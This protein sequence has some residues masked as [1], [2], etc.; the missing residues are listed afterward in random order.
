[1]LYFHFSSLTT[2]RDEGSR[3]SRIR[4]SV[5][6]TKKIQFKFPNDYHAIGILQLPYGNIVEP[7]EMW[8]SGKNKMSR[9]DYYGGKIGHYLLLEIALASFLG[10]AFCFASLQPEIPSLV[11][12]DLVLR[13]AKIC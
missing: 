8:Y 6:K 4:R 7:F 5:A 1:M 12:S 9:M 13:V 10:F 3:P 11:S 2:F